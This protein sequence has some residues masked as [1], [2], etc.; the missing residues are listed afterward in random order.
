[1]DAKGL[2]K[3]RAGTAAIN[4][5]ILTTGTAVCGVQAQG[6]LTIAEPVTAGD[7]MTIG[8]IVYTFRATADADAAYEIDLGAGEAA[9]KQNIVKTILGTDGRT[10]RHPTVSCAAAFAGDALVLTARS[11]GVAGNAIATTETFSHISNVFDAATMGTTT[12]GVDTSHIGEAGDMLIDDTYLYV[13]YKTGNVGA[14]WRRI[15]LGNAY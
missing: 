3:G 15:A 7:T 13:C 12:A 5:K 6:T 10:T 1:M 4:K 2:I 11:A 9:T 14:N 8:G